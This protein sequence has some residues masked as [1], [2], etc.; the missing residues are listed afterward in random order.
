VTCVGERDQFSIRSTR[1]QRD[2][3]ILKFDDRLTVWQLPQS[4]VAAEQSVAKEVAWER[5]P[6]AT[7]DLSRTYADEVITFK[8]ED[9]CEAAL[10]FFL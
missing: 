9:R 4:S 3:D 5:L 7:I 8:V 10:G 2:S 6:I 1:W